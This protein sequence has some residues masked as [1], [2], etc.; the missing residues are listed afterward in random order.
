M[1]RPVG[2]LSRDAAP[3]DIVEVAV[4]AAALSAAALAQG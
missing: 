3:D 1:T 4:L 2:S